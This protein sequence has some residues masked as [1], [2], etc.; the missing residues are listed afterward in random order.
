M[1]FR[2]YYVSLFYDFINNDRYTF[3]IGKPPYE[4]SDVKKTY[5]RIRINDYSFPEH[6]KL[7]KNAKKLI[8]GILVLDPDK[9]FT[10][11]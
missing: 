8:E 3:L 5:K 4:T 9:R 7:S 10:F 1:V 6:I 11:D 2:S